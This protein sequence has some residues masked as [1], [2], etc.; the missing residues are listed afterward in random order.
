MPKPKREVYLPFDGFYNSWSQDLIDD[1][2]LHY[3]TDASGESLRGLSQRLDSLVSHRYIESAYSKEYASQFTQ[4]LK[5]NIELDLKLS[6]KELDSP[7][8]YNFATDKIVCSIRIADIA[9]MKAYIAKE[10]L[11]TELEQAIKDRF[12]SGS[13]FYSFYPNSLKDWESDWTKWE[14]PQLSTVLEVIANH[15]C[16]C[17]EFESFDSNFIFGHFGDTVRGNGLVDNWIVDSIPAD[18]KPIFDRMESNYR[19]LRDKEG[20]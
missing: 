15:A 4:Y 5:E 6:F 19:R 3:F 12:T 10:K 14:S 20:F 7:R 9:K 16:Q 17:K 11:E 8:E 18:K 13:G 2:I 1:A